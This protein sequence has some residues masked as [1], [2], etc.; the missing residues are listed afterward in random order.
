MLQIIYVLAVTLLLSLFLCRT[1]LWIHC[2]WLTPSWYRV[3]SQSVQIIISNGRLRESP[4]SHISQE[5]RDWLEC[6]SMQTVWHVQM[7]GGLQ[8]LL[9]MGMYM[10]LAD[11]SFIQVPDSAAKY[12]TWMNRGS[13]KSSNSRSGA[14]LPLHR[15][16]NQLFGFRN[17]VW[18]ESNH[19]GQW[20]ANRLTLPSLYVNEMS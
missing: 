10:R 20:L 15:Y 7:E 3:F 17:T 1:M 18:L 11:V 5:N 2:W 16:C 12:L 9:R 13:Y 4:V 6:R 19:L 8:C 14:L